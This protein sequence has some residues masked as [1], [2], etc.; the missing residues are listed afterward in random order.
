M[1]ARPE[2]VA[3]DY[4]ALAQEY[5]RHLGDEL[6]R[7]VRRCGG[8]RCTRCLPCGPALRRAGIAMVQ[9]AGRLPL[10]EAEHPSRRGYLRAIR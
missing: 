6:A 3:R 4:D 1:T 9:S 5:T 10:A 7:K 8:G 2:D